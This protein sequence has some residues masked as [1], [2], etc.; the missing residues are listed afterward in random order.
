MKIN[1]KKQQ[2]IEP[3]ELHYQAHAAAWKYLKRSQNQPP[4]LSTLVSVL[5]YLRVFQN[6][7][8]SCLL[9]KSNPFSL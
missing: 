2:N 6:H 8:V 3:V 9:L 1:I 5:A 7:G 4:S